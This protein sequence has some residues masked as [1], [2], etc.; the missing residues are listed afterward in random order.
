MNVNEYL[1][2]QYEYPP[3]WLLVS[4]IYMGELHSNLIQYRATNS[5]FKAIANA[6]R[7]AL[8][9]NEHGFVQVDSPEDYCVVLMA[10]LADAHPHHVGVYYDGKVLHALPSGNLYQDLSSIGDQFLKVEYWVKRND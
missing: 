5:S 2:K 9:N 1:A 6:F 3:C 8:H 4:D 10:K 7:I